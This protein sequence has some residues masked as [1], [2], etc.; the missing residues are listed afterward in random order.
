[1][2]NPSTKEIE[3]PA[4]NQ[5]VAKSFKLENPGDNYVLYRIKTTAPKRYMVRPNNGLIA[6]RSQETIKVSMNLVKDPTNDFSKYDKFQVQSACA[7]QTLPRTEEEIKACWKT[8][9]ADTSTE[10]IKHRIIAKII[11]QKFSPID[12]S[13]LIS[14]SHFNSSLEDSTKGGPD[15]DERSLFDS[16]TSLSVGH[17]PVPATLPGAA[18][19]YSGVA[20][21]AGVGS[22]AGAAAA[23]STGAGAGAGAGAVAGAGA[24][25][26][27]SA[28]SAVVPPVASDMKETELSS[29]DDREAQRGTTTAA[30]IVAS[31]TGVSPTT[32]LE[33]LKREK[34]QL[35]KENVKLRKS[36][37]FF[38]DNKQLWIVLLAFLI[39]YLVAQFVK[40]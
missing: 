27:T 38:V 25:T 34:D 7:P 29:T 24:G 14:D 28:S 31:N 10:I 17:A 4:S 32:Q 23:A 40:I 36:P 21:E 13:D 19:D 2:L 20:K 33:R 5:V 18:L 11:Q 39:G 8:L 9:T 1:M 12:K 26:G 37:S 3:F 6:P 30:S 35:Q 15:D 22:G 16:S